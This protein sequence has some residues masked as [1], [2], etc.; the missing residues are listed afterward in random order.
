MQRKEHALPQPQALIHARFLPMPKE[1]NYLYLMLGLLAA[2][3][4]VTA[5]APLSLLA[6]VGGWIAVLSLLG[7]AYLVV[8]RRGQLLLALLLGAAAFLPFVWLGTHPQAL[9][10]RLANGI[11]IVNVGFWVLFT[12]YIGLIV[13]RGILAARRIGSNEVYGAIYVYLLIGVVF[14][15]VYQLLLA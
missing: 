4:L 14:A 10:P 11:Y 1:P 5:A 2:V 12:C 9:D 3:V 6:R 8:E 7:T 15:A 13:F